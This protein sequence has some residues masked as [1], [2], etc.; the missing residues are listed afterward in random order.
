MSV[1]DLMN[2]DAEAVY[3]SYLN[4][5]AGRIS[6]AKKGIFSDADHKKITDRILEEGTQLGE[7]GQKQ[8]K[9]DVLKFNVMYDLILGRPPKDMIADPGS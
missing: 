1:K 9:K 4:Q 2:R 7:K 8:A 6:F 5:L 3:N